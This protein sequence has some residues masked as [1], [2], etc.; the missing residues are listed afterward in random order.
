[1]IL[2]SQ[3]LKNIFNDS[4]NNKEYEVL[5]YTSFNH[6]PINNIIKDGNKIYIIT[7]EIGGT[8]VNEGKEEIEETNDGPMIA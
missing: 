1:M 5:V 6:Y 4:N 2:N 7:E 8:L 3:D